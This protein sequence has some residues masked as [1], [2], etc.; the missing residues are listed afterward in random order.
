TLK[1]PAFEWVHVQLHQQK[2]MISLSPPTICN[3]ATFETMRAPERVFLA[4]A[5]KA[6]R[7]TGETC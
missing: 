3:S 4:Y 5:R 7:L 6:E 2:G 1:M